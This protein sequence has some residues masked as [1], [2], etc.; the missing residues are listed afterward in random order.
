MCRLVKMSENVKFIPEAKCYYRI[1]NVAPSLGLSSE[2]S[3]QA[4]SLLFLSTSLCIEHLLSLEN[5]ERTRLACLKYLQDLFHFFYPEQLEIVKNAYISP[6]L[7][8]R[9]G[10]PLREF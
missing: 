4:L 5:S 2:K 8:R 9:F 6:D 1:G 10:T 3:D 7:G